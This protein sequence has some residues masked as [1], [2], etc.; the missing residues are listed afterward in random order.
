MKEQLEVVANASGILH[1]PDLERLVGVHAADAVALAYVCGQQERLVI[2]RYSASVDEG[3]DLLEAERL[4]LPG[5]GGDDGVRV[6]DGQVVLIHLCRISGRGA[7]HLERLPQ[8]GPADHGRTP[9]SQSS[10]R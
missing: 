8:N 3:R 5:H 1:G 4:D 6:E 9:P 7:E 10:V 2:T